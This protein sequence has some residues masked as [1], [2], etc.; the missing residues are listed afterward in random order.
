MGRILITGGAGFLGASMAMHLTRFGHE[1]VIFDRKEAKGST[2]LIGS[3]AE[4]N[5]IWDALDGISEVYHLAGVLGTSELIHDNIVAIDSNIVGTVNVLEACREHG[6]TKVFYPTKPNDWLNTYSITKK[7]G[8]DFAQ[9]YRL[10]HKMDIR[11]LRWLNAYGPGQKLFPVRKAI[12]T[13]ILQA[14]YDL[15]LEIFGEGTQ[16]VDLIHV[17]DLAE[18][19][20]AYM[21]L[22]SCSGE[23]R[24]TGCTVRMSVNETVELIIKLARSKSSVKHLPMRPGEYQDQPIE[25]LENLSAAEICGIETSVDIEAGLSETIEYYRNLPTS[26]LEDA[27]KFYYGKLSIVTNREHVGNNGAG[28]RD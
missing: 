25:L 6:I 20:A 2:S 26:H 7:A 4:Y 8:E 17:G 23:V 5:Q 10:I 19:T 16:P 21:E 12:P 18:I 11:I 3:I 13:W 15:P 1:V 22:P 28:N 14:L 9:M 24:D 27:L